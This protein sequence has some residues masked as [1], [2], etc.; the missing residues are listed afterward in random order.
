MKKIIIA[1]DSFKGTLSSS[2][3]CDIAKDCINKA[4]PNCEVIQ[5]P[6]ADGGE[7]TVDCF[8]KALN[9]SKVNISV[10]DSYM[11]K[12]ET[13]YALKDN[14][15][16]IEIASSS[17]LPQVKNN[18]N[19]ALTSTYGIGEQIYDAIS[20]GATKIVLG[21]GGS[22][23]NDAG[24][25]CAC[26][27]KAKFYD[28][29]N[30]EFVPTGKTL[31]NVKKIDISKT[32][33]LLKDIEIIAM[34]DVAN[35][36]YGKKGAS[37]VYAPQKGADKKMVKELDKGLKHLSKIIKKDFKI[38]VSK[39]KGSGAAGAFGAGSIAFFN[40]SL[41][42]GI[43]TILD[44]TN[45]NDYLNDCDFVITGEGKLDNQSFNGKVI[46]GI[47]KR[48]NAFNVK[49]I[50]IPGC[51]DSTLNNINIKNVYGIYPTIKEKLPFEIIKKNAKSNY[52][53]TLTNVLN[54]LN[55]I[56]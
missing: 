1:S 55:N 4:F 14:I 19:P 3:I 10:N 8:I 6:I 53:K 34:C 28:K 49:V 45:F 20:K 21:L 35:K 48:C 31:K 9:A 50:I 23:T 29:Y 32:K 37:Y 2:D 46:S 11:K 17:G 47:L 16:F 36:M 33:E 13:Y 30:N 5:I 24:C 27:L 15:A 41:K 38:N 12:I 56:E 26:A 22:S 51:I 54:S 44:I 25:G 7:G 42:S 18:K 52:I 39:I 40:A 43:D